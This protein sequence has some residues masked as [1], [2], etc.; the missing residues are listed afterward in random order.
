MNASA[1][2][3]AAKLSTG[4]KGPNKLSR[5]SK[6]IIFDIAPL[7]WYSAS[8][9]ISEVVRAFATELARG[10][11]A[12]GVANVVMEETNHFETLL[13]KS[14]LACFEPRQYDLMDMPSYG[15]IV[16]DMAIMSAKRA[17]AHG[18]SFAM[19][20]ALGL[21]DDVTRGSSSMATD[22][23]EDDV[24]DE[25]P[26][27]KGRVMGDQMGRR[28]GVILTDGLGGPNNAIGTEKVEEEEK[29]I[30][31]NDRVFGKV[32]GLY[33]VPILRGR[34]EILDILGF[35]VSF[36]DKR[37]VPTRPYL[38]ACKP[39]GDW[40]AECAPL[41]IGNRG[42]DP[43]DMHL[44]YRDLSGQ[45]GWPK[46]NLRLGQSIVFDFHDGGSGLIFCKLR[47]RY[48]MLEACST[49][50]NEIV[51]CYCEAE[52]ANEYGG[53]IT[54]GVIRARVDLSVNYWERPKKGPDY[55]LKHTVHHWNTFP[56]IPVSQ[57]KVKQ[58]TPLCGWRIRQAAHYSPCLLWLS[59]PLA[60][61]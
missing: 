54:A 32:R 23:E 42:L 29:K 4:I 33:T 11:L 22:E 34:F 61:R 57:G 37:C 24:V 14:P 53:G 50:E 18:G 60:C 38:T 56:L 7:N 1:E 17:V 55:W 46:V 16:R 8:S 48:E 6:K 35:D 30:D 51:T 9:T 15:D 26:E 12:K 5:S 45:W 52:I 59:H 21:D 27:Y 31:Y 20:Q 3:I 40:A 43:K 58:K 47:L 28:R 44:T 36:L 13:F 39:Y 25:L 41:W 10:C 2:A 49:D 19:A